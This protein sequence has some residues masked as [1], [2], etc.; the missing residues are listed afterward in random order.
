MAAIHVSTKFFVTQSEFLKHEYTRP[1]TD[2]GY[3]LACELKPLR[4][5]DLPLPGK[6]RLAQNGWTDL[7]EVTD[8]ELMRWGLLAR[9]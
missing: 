4:K 6:L 5:V 2:V 3:L 7:S 8:R 1:K 9:P